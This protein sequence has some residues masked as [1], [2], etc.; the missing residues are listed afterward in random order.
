MHEL[1]VIKFFVEFHKK[2]LDYG[3]RTT[4]RRDFKTKGLRT[5][6]RNLQAPKFTIY[7]SVERCFANIC[8]RV[9]SLPTKGRTLY[10]I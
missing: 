1:N 9:A 6:I 8:H 7:S 2:N 4:S 5:E 10:K 3:S